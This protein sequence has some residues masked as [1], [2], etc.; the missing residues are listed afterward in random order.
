MKLFTNKIDTPEFKEVVAFLALFYF[1]PIILLAYRIIPIEAN[2]TILVLMSL[3]MVAYAI[4]KPIEGRELGLRKDNFGRSMFWSSLVT[5]AFIV[6]LF[7]IY[8]TGAIRPKYSETAIFYLFY[9]FLSAPL[10]EFVFRSLMF[11]E[12]KIYFK[13]DWFRVLL[14]AVIFSFAHYMYR[15]LSVMLLTFAAGLLWG[16]VYLKKPNFWA[17]A[18]SH[19]IVGAVTIFLGFV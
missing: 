3:I 5:I 14:S 13:K 7:I 9:V 19:A 2:P 6:V 12:L 17:L 16:Y 15:D 11:H 10:Q 4:T 1:L 18:I 8:K